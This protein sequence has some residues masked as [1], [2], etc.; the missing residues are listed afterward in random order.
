MDMDPAQQQ[1]D[2]NSPF[3]RLLAAKYDPDLETAAIGIVERH[4]ELAR[5]EWPGPDNGGKPFVTGSTALHY[6][7]NDGK[8]R[9]VLKRL[10]LGADPNA[11]NAQWYRSVLSWAAN[12]ARLST[13]KLQHGGDPRHSENRTPLRVAMESGYQPAIDFLH[14]LGAA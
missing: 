5:L 14:R 12:N 3:F 13:I 8:D 11:S 9:L 6:A 10:E 2:E 4:P 1:F 7:A